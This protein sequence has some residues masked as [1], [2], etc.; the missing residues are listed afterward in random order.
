[1]SGLRDFDILC[2]A[3]H[4]CG[5][6][7]AANV[8]HFVKD[9]S[10]DRINFHGVENLIEVCLKNHMRLV[11]V[12]TLSV[13][14][15]TEAGK[16]DR[17]YENDL[18]FGQNLDNDYIRT[19]FLAERAI[20]EARVERG[21]DAVILRA[22]NLMGRYSDGEFQINFLTN[23]FMRSLAAFHRLGACPVTALADVVE[24]SPIDFTAAAMLTLAGVN[25]S[26]S[27]FNV[28]N[29]HT[30]TRGD[31]IFALNRHGLKIA[32]VTEK[33]FTGIMQAASE[34]DSYS[35]SIMSMTA[36]EA[37]EGENL[38]PVESDNCFTVNALYRLGFKW[39]IVDDAYLER[40]ISAVETLEFF[41]NL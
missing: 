35:E 33:E 1:M 30:V 31:I 28:N 4:N 5:I 2:E 37:R 8:K 18:Y 39:P 10:L 9:D 38:V 36:Y 7:C 6:N 15:S 41:Q 25:S 23:A 27:V 22:G 14:G 21:L 13:G 12:S 17:L 29:N 26:F 34:N 24:L 20:L 32:I 11:Q 16:K 40:I 19:K 3:S